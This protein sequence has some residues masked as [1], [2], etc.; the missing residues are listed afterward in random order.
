MSALLENDST[1]ICQQGSRRKTVSLFGSGERV[2]TA[3]TVERNAMEECKSAAKLK[4]RF[5]E[6]FQRSDDRIAVEFEHGGPTVK[7]RASNRDVPEEEAI[8]SAPWKPD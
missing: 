3:G 7:R 5:T 2:E 8:S 1:E 6:G 4:P